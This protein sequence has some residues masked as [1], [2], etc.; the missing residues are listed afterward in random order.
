MNQELSVT[1]DDLLDDIAQ[2]RYVSLSN[3]SKCDIQ[4]K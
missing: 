4:Y 2:D 3:V 1:D